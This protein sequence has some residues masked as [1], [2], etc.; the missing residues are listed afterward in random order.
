MYPWSMDIWCIYGPCICGLCVNGPCIYGP[1]VQSKDDYVEREGRDI[2]V[3]DQQHIAAFISIIKDISNRIG[4]GGTVT[5]TLVTLTASAVGHTHIVSTPHCKCVTH[6][7]A[8]QNCIAKIAP[9]S[10]TKI[11]YC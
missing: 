2:Q 4:S 3:L 6:T 10:H 5:V 7:S 9:Y 1:C 11:V 8:Q